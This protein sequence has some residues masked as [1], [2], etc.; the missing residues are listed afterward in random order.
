MN[1]IKSYF[2][3]PWTPR[4]VGNI[5]LNN[6]LYIVLGIAVIVIAVV[7]PRFIK[8]PSLINILSQ[9]AAYLPAALGIG[10]CIVL[11]GTDLSA[12]RV[13]GLTACIS[14]SLLQGT[15]NL[16]NK[17][18]P[19]ME[20]FPIIAVI[21]IAMIIGALIGSFNGFFVAK[22]KLHPFIVTL[23]TQL[24]VYSLLLLYVQMGNNH[25]TAISNLDASYTNFVKGSFLSIGGTSI[26][27]YVW[28]A[29][30]LT[31]I[32]WFVWNKT[33]FGKNM[34]ALGANEEAAKVSGVNVFMT[35]IMVFALAGAM[36][37]FT[38]FIE[39]A[40]IGSNTVNTGLN[41]ELDA[42]AACVIGGVSFVG[43]IGK[44]S[45]IVIGVL[46]L[47]LIFVGL[48]MMS[49][50]PNLQYLIKGGIIL[51]A[52]ALDMRKYLVKK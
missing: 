3:Q 19:G 51:F 45:G 39:G 43:G 22:F 16:A 17:M 35:T 11:T 14:A 42:I 44:I 7:N 48:S 20:T 47:R 18:W 46:M 37:G 5:L 9:T 30:A 23:G 33:T 1:R 26:P 40:R 36:Y 2:A 29:I 41:Y 4:R 12:G 28:F 49:I 10:G 24:I 50:D 15:A 25:G 8:I 34:F 38:G 13:V 52:C 6:A 21:P 31:I 32:M 27:N